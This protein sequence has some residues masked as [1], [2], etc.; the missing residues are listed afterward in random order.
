CFAGVAGTPC[1]GEPPS[2]PMSTE[3][4]RA[5]A[6][7]LT[8]GKV[9]I[10]GG[11]AHNTTDLASTDIY[12]AVNNCFAGQAGS[13]CA[14]Q[15]TPVMNVGRDDATASLLPNGKVL[16]AGGFSNDHSVASSELYDPANNCFAGEAGTPC[17]ALTTATMNAARDLATATL[18]STGKV[19]IAG[20]E[21]FVDNVSLSTTELYDPTA[22]C[23]AGETDTP[24]AGQ[25][26]ADLTFAR[27][28]ATATPLPNG[29]VLIAG[30]FDIAS[31]QFVTTADLYDPANNCFAGQ[32]GTPGS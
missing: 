24:C 31:S 23:F 4:E 17:A 30:G 29:K 14:G 6:T 2:P 1:A 28:A 7:M 32:A 9:L 13:P 12:D 5:T 26:T 16:V 20:G 25:T 3:R 22:N 18:L 21:N 27:F 11:F 15:T 10:A 19:L 8:N